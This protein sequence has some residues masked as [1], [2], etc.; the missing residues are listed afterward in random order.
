MISISDNSPFTTGA[1]T[2]PDAAKLLNLPIPRLRTWVIGR[3]VPDQSSGRKK[4][5]P[6]GS[7]K[8][9]GIARDRHFSFHTLIELFI[10]AHLRGLGVSLR[11]LRQARRELAEREKTPHPFA[12]EGLLT[13]RKKLLFD[14]GTKALLELGAGG[15]TSFEEVVAPFCIRLDFDVTTR[16]A[17]RY[18]PLGKDKPIIVDPAHAFGRPTIVGT[19]IVTENV[20]ALIRGGETVEDVASDFGLAPEV[21]SEVW[22]FENRLAA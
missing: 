12:L 5:Y 17:C 1:Y 2:L 16:M 3:T 6:A 7:I 18:H 19:N 10:L 11:V 4:V 8:T 15:Q 14:L 21:V 20:A 22:S 13:D 9:H